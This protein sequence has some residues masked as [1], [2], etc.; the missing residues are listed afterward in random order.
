M[1]SGHRQTIPLAEYG[2]RQGLSADQLVQAVREKRLQMTTVN[3]QK[4]VVLPKQKPQQEK[5]K[6]SLARFSIRVGV[7]LIVLTL[8]TAGAYIGNAYYW[9]QSAASQLSTATDEAGLETVE[10]AQIKASLAEQLTIDNTGAIPEGQQARIDHVRRYFAYRKVKQ[11]L[12]SVEGVRSILATG[13]YEKVENIPAVVDW[14]LYE[15]H[16]IHGPNRFDVMVS[17]GTDGSVRFMFK[18]DG[19]RWTLFGLQLPSHKG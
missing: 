8:C 13:S 6:T 7:G 19:L 12:P 1:D 2:K 14:S 3:G 11:Q 16:E 18:R 10:I 17:N 5:E 9:V 4:H 15:S